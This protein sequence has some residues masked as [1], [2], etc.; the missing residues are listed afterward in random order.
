MALSVARAAEHRG[1][2]APGDWPNV[3]VS[4]LLEGN[5]DPEIAELAG[6]NRQV[7]GWD[8]ELLVAAAC[9]R[10]QV[11]AADTA[12]GHLH[13]RGTREA[14]ALDAPRLSA[15]S[16]TSRALNRQRGERGQWPAPRCHALPVVH[17]AHAHAE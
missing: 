12:A 9:E 4:L 3:A 17:R 2:L 11:S 10:H 6:L 7:N 15:S 13:R 8:T 5:E 16:R 14:V 1:C